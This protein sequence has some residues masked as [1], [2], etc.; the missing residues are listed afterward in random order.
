[1]Q[2]ELLAHDCTQG[3]LHTAKVVPSPPVTEIGGSSQARPTL[4]HTHLC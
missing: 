4:F 3:G 2:V 1:M